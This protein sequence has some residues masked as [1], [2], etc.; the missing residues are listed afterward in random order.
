MLPT[1][2]APYRPVSS[3]D[4]LKSR[5]WRGLLAFKRRTVV[6]GGIAL[7]FVWWLLFSYPQHG[8]P[9][10]MAPFLVH[11]E[12]QLLLAPAPPEEPLPPPPPAVNWT[13]RAE[14]VKQAFLHAYHGYEEFASPADELLPLSNKSIN[15]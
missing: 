9:H 5:R 4:P 3:D 14:Q 1:H 10:R 15:K 2:G 12:E 11:E 6:L 13:A 8:Y 7:L